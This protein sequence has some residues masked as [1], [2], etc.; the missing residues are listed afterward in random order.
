M[1]IL[2][3]HLQQI[4][5]ATTKPGPAQPLGG[6]ILQACSDPQALAGAQALAGRLLSEI[7]K[8]WPGQAGRWAGDASM[9]ASWARG[10]LEA[11]ASDPRRLAAALARCT[12][13]PYPPDLGVLLAEA[14]GGGVS[15]ELAESSFVRTCRACGAIPPAFHTLTP[16]EL[17]AGQQ[18]G[19]AEL[20]EAAA[21]ERNV[22]RWRALLADAAAQP[23]LPEVPMAPA[24]QL[25]AP[26]PARRDV[27]A[28]WEAIQRG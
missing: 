20:R 4:K 26:P 16:A 13:R 21:T 24:G 14:G 6:L 2:S 19:W 27:K 8:R 25:P 17:Y 23:Q 9:A 5:R 11:G 28:L 1:K 7:S 18:F 22:K 10:L 3:Q 15:N 12:G